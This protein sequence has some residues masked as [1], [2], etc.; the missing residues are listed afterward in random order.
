MRKMPVIAD[1]DFPL[2]SAAF[3]CNRFIGVTLQR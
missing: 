1:P 2:F 3:Y